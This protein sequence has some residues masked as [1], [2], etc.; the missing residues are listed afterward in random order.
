MEK[1]RMP[2]KLKGLVIGKIPPRNENERYVFIDITKGIG[3]LLVVICHINI[4]PGCMSS[5][6]NSFHMPLFFFV[7]GLFFNQY[8]KP[9]KL[10]RS[11]M[12]RLIKPYYIWAVP[13]FLIYELVTPKIYSSAFSQLQDFFLGMR[14]HNYVFTSTMW[15]LT[16]L[17]VVYFIAFLYSQILQ[18]YKLVMILG[19]LGLL[20][21]VD[22]KD[23]IL[24]LNAD[25]SLYMMPF[26]LIAYKL[27]CHILTKQVPKLIVAMSVSILTVYTI[28]DYIVPK[29]IEN[30]N[31]YNCKFGVYPINY[32]LGFSGIFFVIC[33]SRFLE[34]NKHAANFF[35]FWGKNSIIV[36][37]IHQAFIIHPLNCYGLINGGF[38]DNLIRLIIILLLS[39]LSILFI[40][41][42]LKWS[43]N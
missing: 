43:I 31:F 14:E 4:L 18:K 1:Q 34:F 32:L 36:L 30:M 22:K 29:Q 16:S 24:P 3:I 41:K 19:L 7:S 37:I 9:A 25:V 28:T 38:C 5:T 12:N 33:I 6:V 21:Y 40:N 26:F 20:L 10:F 39:Y 13:M 27:R 42:Y 35:V 15:F 8:M 17:F 2:L 11:K 23:I